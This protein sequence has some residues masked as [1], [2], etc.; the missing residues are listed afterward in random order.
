MMDIAKRIHPFQE[1]TP[2][3]YAYTAP[4]V[5]YLDGWIKIGYTGK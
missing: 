5:T 3:I 4:G 1:I 2:M